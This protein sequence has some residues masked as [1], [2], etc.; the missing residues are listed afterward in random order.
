MYPPLEFQNAFER[1]SHQY[2]FKILQKYGISS[3]FIDRIKGLY[4][5]ILV[6]V[7]INGTRG[8]IPMPSAVQQGCPL[9]MLLYA[10]S[11]PLLSMLEGKV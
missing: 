5:N 2:L 7:Q 9:S 1:I 11:P 8:P 10:L 6:C 4:E 3:W